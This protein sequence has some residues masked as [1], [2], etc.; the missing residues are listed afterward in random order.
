MEILHLEVFI[1]NKVALFPA[2]LFVLLQKRDERAVSYGVQSEVHRNREEVCPKLTMKILK[3]NNEACTTAFAHAMLIGL[4]IG[5][6]YSTALSNLTYACPY[7]ELFVLL[8]SCLGNSIRSWTH[9]RKVVEHAVLFQ[10]KANT[11]GKVKEDMVQG[12]ADL[13]E[14]CSEWVVAESA[15][16]SHY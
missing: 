13:K 4:L 2:F 14:D 10:L 3:V 11:D 8:K 16:T 5:C 12:L 9:G 6:K 1:F 15:G 7:D